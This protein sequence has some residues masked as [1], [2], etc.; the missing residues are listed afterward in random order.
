MKFFCT[1]FFLFFSVVIYSQNN[2]ISSSVFN[3][4]SSLPIEGVFVKLL[5]DEKTTTT[6]ENGNFYFYNINESSNFSIELS[7]IGFEMIKIE[8]VDILSDKSIF[9]KP[10]KSTTLKEVVINSGGISNQYKQISKLD[11]K[12]RGIN[13]SQEILRLVP[14]L[15]IGQHQGGGKA[16]QIFLRGFDCDH[17]TDVSLNVDGML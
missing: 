9:M 1:L 12:M 5:P 15:F 10:L 8:K 17:G 7:S 13:N 16:E 11:I 14:G 4:V 6:D 3:E 2:V